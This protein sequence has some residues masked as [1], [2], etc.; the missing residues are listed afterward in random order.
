MSKQKDTFRSAKK[1]RTRAHLR[2]VAF[3][4][5]ERRGF[6]TTTIADIASA[7]DISAR[8]VL[9]YFPT[10]EDVI[11]SWVSDGF[12]M[13]REDLLRRLPL[14]DPDGALFAA[15]RATLSDYQTNAH[16]FRTLD[17][18]IVSNTAM[19]ARKEQVTAEFAAQVA[20]ILAE[21]RHERPLPLLIAETLS[22]TVF[23]LMRASV[24][25]WLRRGGGDTILDI[26]DEAT[27]ALRSHTQKW[28]GPPFG[29]E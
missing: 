22:G 11:V 24:R 6:E 19:S 4:L 1:D 7:A 25:E 10:K 13:L 18:L 12:I 3:D 14:T 8:S 2:K 23:S 20:A 15:A 5:I 17:R 28:Q 16:F 9:R 21:S 27:A 29:I 26:F